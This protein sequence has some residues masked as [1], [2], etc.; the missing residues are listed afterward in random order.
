MTRK[1]KPDLAGIDAVSAVRLA[2]LEKRGI[3]RALVP[4]ERFADGRI[5]RGGEPMISFCD[6]DYLGLSSHPRVIAA[7]V[8]AT[9]TYGA[10][11]GAAR[12]ITG[13]NPLNEKLEA[14]LAALKGLP[15]ARV[16]GSGYL[17]NAGAI[18]ALVGA[19]DL[20]VMDELCHASMHAGARLSGARIQ[21]FSHNNAASAAHSLQQ[22]DATSHAL[23]LTETVFSMDGDLAP[24][25]EL[26]EV[27][28]Q[29][30]AWMMTDDAHG[31]GVVPLDNPA[32]IQMGTLS[33]AVGAYGGYVAG[34]QSFVDLMASRARTFVYATGLPPGVLASALA[35]LDVM[36]DEPGLGKK[37][38]ANARLFGSLIGRA[39]VES[40]IVPVV[41]G[42]AEAA[43]KASAL[44][45]SQG[46]LVT[47]IR[48][49]TV[50][51]GTARLR[52]TFSARHNEADIRRLAALVL[53]AL[54]EAGVAK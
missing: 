42:E 17:A 37:A 54:A 29:T 39:N 30:G 20:I 33:K 23:L 49:P 18:P 13:D 43:M 53:K 34:P 47:P 4:T 41:L 11:A 9:Q 48:P 51:E 46:L 19:G 5:M 6:N 26:G 14:R 45:A 50:P 40:A 16:F 38:L 21:T 36:E 22:R 3:R 44:L 28:Q 1:T 15:A 35:A 7:A 2:M 10:G 32:P 52:I 24:L 27:A 31:L 12:L 25:A 8:E